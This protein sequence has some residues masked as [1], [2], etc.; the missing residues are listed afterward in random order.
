MSGDGMIQFSRCD[1]PST[2]SLPPDCG[3]V[4]VN[5][6]GIT[7]LEYR[8]LI[9]ADSTERITEGGIVIP[10]SIAEKQDMAQVKATVVAIGGNCFED[11]KDPE[12]PHAGSRVST[13]K[14]AGFV[15][16]GKDGGE[17]RIVNDKDITAL[18][19]E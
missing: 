15:I 9:K 18:L 8:V 3:V 5:T 1:D 11:W 12:L 16:K 7:P 13:K 4:T 14:Y 10:E 17:Y 19:D 2:F 6:S